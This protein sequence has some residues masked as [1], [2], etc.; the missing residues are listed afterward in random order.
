MKAGWIA[1]LLIL[2]GAP[3]MAHPMGNFSINHYSAISLQ[4]DGVHLEYIVD[5]AEIPTFQEMQRADMDA[6]GEIGRAHV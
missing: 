5:M 6:D 2:L 1:L 4:N 3:L